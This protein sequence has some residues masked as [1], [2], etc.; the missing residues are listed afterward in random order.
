MP[1]SVVLESVVTS[2]P[3]SSDVEMGVT[4]SDV[5]MVFASSDVEIVLASVMVLSEVRL[6][7]VV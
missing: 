4:S 6:G 3:A 1:G 7:S 5:E 2:L